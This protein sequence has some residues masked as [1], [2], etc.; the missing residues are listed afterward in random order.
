MPFAARNSSDV[1]VGDVVKFCRQGGKISRGVV[2]YIGHLPSKNDIYLGV[3]LEHESEYQRLLQAK[4]VA[5]ILRKQQSITAMFANK[6]IF[7]HCMT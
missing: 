1:T 6:I 7:K 2:K 4:S 3:E 5:F